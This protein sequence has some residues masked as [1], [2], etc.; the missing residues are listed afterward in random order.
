[1]RLKLFIHVLSMMCVKIVC[2]GTS[3]SVPVEIGDYPYMVS[4]YIDNYHFCG[5]SLIHHSH[6]LSAASCF[7]DITFLKG[8]VKVL[9]GNVNIREHTSAF[10]I[11]RTVKLLI[12]YKHNGSRELDNICIL[13]LDGNP[14]IPSDYVG[15]IKISQSRVWPA[16]GTNCITLDWGWDISTSAETQIKHT[17]M[18]RNLS[19]ISYTQCNEI[20]EGSAIN[21]DN[22]LCAGIPDVEDEACEE[23][24]AYKNAGGPLICNGELFGIITSGFSCDRPVDYELFINVGHYAKWIQTLINWNAETKPF[25]AIVLYP[26][27]IDRSSFAPSSGPPCLLLIF[28]M[29]LFGL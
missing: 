25:Q 29:Q 4:I 12:H 24:L 20:M 7:D 23:I 21:Y 1:M 5:G 2:R 26:M 10:Q 16:P 14:I 28:I 9:M 15:F 19:S 8:R 22:Q 13:R 6:V 17:L 3:E 18:A 11:Y 27:D